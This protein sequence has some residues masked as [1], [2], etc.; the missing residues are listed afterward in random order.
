MGDYARTAP[1]DTFVE[2]R[3]TSHPTELAGL[4]GARLVTAVETEEGRRW[5]ESRIKTLTGGEKLRPAICAATSSSSR[6]HSSW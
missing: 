3:L 4:Q 1:I 6:R 2:T 5:H